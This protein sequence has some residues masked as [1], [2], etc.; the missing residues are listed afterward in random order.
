MNDQDKW[1]YYFGCVATWINH[2]GYQGRGIDPPSF[3]ELAD[4]ASALLALEKK[5]W[6]DGAQQHK[7]E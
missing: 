6:P 1:R 3:Q 2:P 4:Q 5:Q 7:P